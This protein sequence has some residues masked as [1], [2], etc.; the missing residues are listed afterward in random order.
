M[1]DVTYDLATTGFKTNTM[2]RL[3]ESEPLLA[4]D[5]ETQAIYSQAEIQEAKSLIKQ[6]KNDPTTQEGYTKEDIKLTKQIARVSGLSYPSLVKVTHFIFSC[7][8]NHSYIII[9][10]SYNEEMRIWEWIKNYKGTLIVHN[11]LFDLKIMY[12]RL[13]QLPKNY[14]DTQLIAKTL[15]N[16]ADDF[17]ARTGLKTLMNGYY[18]PKW[19]MLDD[20][21]YNPE[22]LQKKS[23][24]NYC[25][26]DGCSTYYLYQL[27]QAEIKKK[28]KSV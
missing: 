7:S 21:G 3:L 8:I 10:N 16:D 1:I 12:E 11:S 15:I 20:E 22:D 26:I 28:M 23:F 14:E 27:L 17:N 25:A 24:L 6:W 18:D 19:A 4:F 2:L 5:T 13:K 9:P